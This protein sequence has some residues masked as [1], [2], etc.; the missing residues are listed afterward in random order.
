MQQQSKDEP[1][2]QKRRR[3]H[4][5]WHPTFPSDGCAHKSEIVELFKTYRT[6]SV[7]SDADAN[8]E[9]CAHR[10]SLSR[11]VQSIQKSWKWFDEKKK[12]EMKRQFVGGSDADS[13]R[14]WRGHVAPQGA[15][16]HV[17]RHGRRASLVGSRKLLH[18]ANEQ[19]PLFHISLWPAQLIR[20]TCGS[21]LKLSNVQ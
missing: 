17:K 5:L 3:F 19:L 1:A 4:V 2:E 7:S 6:V 10:Q 18:V 16:F 21:D 9:T 12:N 13:S 20:S 8:F 15:H 11:S 14:G